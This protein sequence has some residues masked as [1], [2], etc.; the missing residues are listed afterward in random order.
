MKSESVFAA[1][2]KAPESWLRGR[3][4]NC[5]WSLPGQRRSQKPWEIQGSLPRSAPRLF[6]ERLPV[7]Q[8]SASGADNHRQGHDD[9]GVPHEHQR[10]A[11]RVVGD[12]D[13]E[14]AK[15]GRGETT[16]QRGETRRQGR[17]PA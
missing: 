3:A 9:A 7:Q 14:V 12:A 16:K 2:A 6:D 13:A 4:T 11:I 10:V 17:T 5:T 15:S 1:E 8:A